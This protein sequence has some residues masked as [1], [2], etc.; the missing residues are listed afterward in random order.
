MNVKFELM[1]FNE[2]IVSA[3]EVRLIIKAS[4]VIA[5]LFCVQIRLMSECSLKIFFLNGR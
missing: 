2:R 3:Q 5:G 1:H 4:D